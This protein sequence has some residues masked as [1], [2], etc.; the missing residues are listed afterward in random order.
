M[1]VIK[2]LLKTVF[3]VN[4]I[5]E[6]EKIIFSS[7]G[8]QALSLIKDNFH[9]IDTTI[10]Q[11]DGKKKIC[12]IDGGNNEIIGGSNFSIQL[13]RVAAIIVQENKTKKI[14]KEEYYVIGRTIVKNNE[15]FFTVDFFPLTKGSSLLLP[16]KQ[17][18]ELSGLDKTIALGPERA[19]IQ[20]AG[21]IARKCSELLLAKKMI[22]ELHE[23]DIIVFDTHL[24]SMI[25]NEEKYWRL[26]YQEAQTRNIF[27][28]GLCKTTNL[29]TSSGNAVTTALHYLHQSSTQEIKAWWYYPCVIISDPKHPAEMYFVKLHPQSKY[30][31]RFEVYKEQHTKQDI[32]NIINLLAQ[33]SRDYIFPGYP[34]GLIVADK[35]ARVSEQEKEYYKVKLQVMAGKDYEKLQQSIH[36]EDAHAVLDNI[37]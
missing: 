12:F 32:E 17:D 14:I 35:E 23:R 30:I 26:L 4:S 10:Q 6:E 3:F 20:K 5:S 25:T 36:A 31:F 7:E 21:E 9:K 34:Y 18:L 28:T 33:N 11:S 16:E 29:L 37:N 24:K 2:E 27:I 8:Y 15:I 22:A 1:D 13:I 19:N